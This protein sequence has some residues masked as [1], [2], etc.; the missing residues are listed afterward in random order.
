MRRHAFLEMVMPADALA[1]ADK[2]ALA[3]Q[4]GALFDHDLADQPAVAMPQFL[5]M[6]RADATPFLQGLGGLP[7]L[8]VSGAHDP[9]APPFAGR[10]LAEG[11]P[12]ARYVELADASHG[13]PIQ[14]AERVN[15][16][17][18]EHLQ[19]AEA[20]LQPPVKAAAGAAP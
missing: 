4:L 12:G 11:I 3:E 6:R 16:L 17:L 20:A 10:A 18:R 15:A 7:T 1:R 13:A 9:I 19:G 8:V 2:D 5:A 14:H